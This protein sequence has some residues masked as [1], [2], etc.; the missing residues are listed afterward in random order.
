M[1]A[2]AMALLTI[3]LVCVVQEVRSSNP[4]E[5]LVPGGAIMTLVVH[6]LLRER[7]GATSPELRPRTVQ[8]V[9]GAH[10]LKETPSHPAAS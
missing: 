8:L 10:L 6:D 2:L 3:G 5:F 7:R 4:V 1:H 9:A